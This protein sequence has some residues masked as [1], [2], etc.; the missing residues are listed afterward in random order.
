MIAHDDSNAEGIPI[1]TKPQ[2][3]L[4]SSLSSRF[5]LY[6]VR[7]GLVIFRVLS[8]QIGIPAIR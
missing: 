4:C 1:L 3:F 5:C 8:R 2:Y 7:L 6:P